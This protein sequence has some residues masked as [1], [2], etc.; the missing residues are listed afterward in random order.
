MYAYIPNHQKRWRIRPNRTTL[1]DD[2]ESSRVSYFE[3]QK[4]SDLD[5]VVPSPVLPEDSKFVFCV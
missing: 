1:F 4:K 2:E 5:P 3:R